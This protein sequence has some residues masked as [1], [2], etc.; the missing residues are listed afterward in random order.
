MVTHRPAPRAVRPRSILQAMSAADRSGLKHFLST[1]FRTT[2]KKFLKALIKGDEALAMQIYQDNPKFRKSLDPNA[3][4][5]KKYGCNTALHYT[6][7]HAMTHLLRSF[8]YNK[9]GNPNKRNAHNQTALHLLCSGPQ[10]MPPEQDDQRRANC[11]QMILKWRGERLDGGAYERADVNATDDKGNTALH[12]AASAGLSTCVQI[13]VNCNANLFSENKDRETPCDCAEKQHHTEL[14]LSLEAQMVFSKDPK[15]MEA[16]D[17]R[18]PYEGLTMQ[19]L[20]E[21]KNNLTEETADMLQVPLFTAGALLRTHDWDKEK[22]QMALLSNAEDCCKRSGVKMPTPPPSKYNSRDNLPSPCTP[23]EDED[24]EKDEDSEEGEKEDG[25]EDC[26]EDEDSQEDEDSEKDEYMD[27]NNDEDEDRLLCALCLCTIPASEYPVDMPC[28]HEFCRECWEGF[29]NLKIQEGA[30]PNI[31]CPACGCSQ[32]VPAEIIE[33]IVSKEMYKRYLLFDIK[34]FVDSN[35]AIKW[36]PN[37]GCERAVILAGQGPGGT[38]TDP[39][40]FPQL[41]APAVDCG[42]GHVFCWQCLGKSHEPCDCQTWQ[43]WQGKLSEMDRQE[44]GGVSE[45][46]EDV[47]NSLWLLNN[48]KPCP[49]CETPI[50]KNE[51]CNHMKCFRCKFN[52][53]WICLDDWRLHSY[54]TG[55]SYTCTRF[56][57]IQ[58]AEERI[59]KEAQKKRKALEEHDHFQEYL[60]SYR[61]HEDRYQL[62]QELLIT[63]KQRIEQLSRALSEREGG[64]PDTTFFDDAMHELLKTRRILACS[65]AY[66]VFLEVNSRKE[67]TFKRMQTDL[68]TV[69]EDLVTLVTQRTPRHKIVRAACLVQQKRQEFLFSVSQDLETFFHDGKW[70]WE[71]LGLQSSELMEYLLRL[72]RNAQRENCH[73]GHPQVLSPLDKDNLSVRLVT[74]L[75]QQ[76][77][78]WRGWGTA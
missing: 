71:L 75:C 3:S 58:L 22:L 55:G 43:A 72:E 31:F 49:N 19:D 67:K 60:K 51:G 56:D 34:A 77:L 48:S 1:T 11:L 36:C 70:D 23:D 24:G 29:L 61:T 35:P 73:R 13:L 32:L 63:G 28:G 53:C 44:G 2:A 42:D 27:A 25:E 7:Q 39:L 17:K 78:S 8:L 41:K 6:S 20:H 50:Q 45:A 65:S 46:R 15:D 62:E 9:G 21:L 5:G 57:A 26:V 38:G 30:G 37:P 68:E 18:K 33:S 16:L 69:T 64:A 12:Y 66:G 47:V 76:Q 4:Y 74:L 10:T 40:I 52:F 59:A 14:A 54:N